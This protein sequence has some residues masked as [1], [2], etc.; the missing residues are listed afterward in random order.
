MYNLKTTVKFPTRIFNGS[1]TTVGN[2]FI[3][4]IRNYTINLLINQLSDHD[5]RI[6]KVES[7]FIPIQDR[8]S[9][10]VRN[11]NSC[12]IA[13]F[14]SKLSAEHWEDIFGGTDVN[15]VS[16]SFLNSYLNFFHVCFTKGKLNPTYRYNP[17]ITRG[18]KVLFHEVLRVSSC[19]S[20]VKCTDV[21]RNTVSPIFRVR[22]G[23]WQLGAFYNTDT[24]A[25]PQNFIELKPPWKYQHIKVLCCN[26]RNLY[27]NCRESNDNLK[28]RYKG[29]CK[30]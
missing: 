5:A 18:V 14:Q 27:M 16:N 15:V 11:I 2:I 13:E 1:S 26:K 12:T 9:C 23:D 21:S 22:G 6:L 24:A 17:W 20:V 19:V 25:Y 29:Y 10:C 30:I 3:D 28:L 7:I 8:T 4:M